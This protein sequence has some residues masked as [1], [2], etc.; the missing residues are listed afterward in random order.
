MILRELIEFLEKQDLEQ[1][2]PLGFTSPHSYR[3]TYRELAFEPAPQVKIKEMLKDARSAVGSTY[4]GW[5]GGEYTME[6][7][8]DVYLAKRGECGEE[9][10][11][12]LLNYMIGLYETER[13]TINLRQTR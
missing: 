5:K 2:V 1:V 4:S 13:Y 12:I 6:E 9:I 10:G 11:T 8:S 7:I 3:G